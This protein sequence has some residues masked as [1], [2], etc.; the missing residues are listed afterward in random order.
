RVK[1]T[2]SVA[3]WGL[4]FALHIERTACAETDSQ[5]RQP[6]VFGRSVERTS[7]GPK[8]RQ[9]RFSTISKGHQDWTWDKIARSAKS[10]AKQQLLPR[11]MFLRTTGMRV[12]R[13]SH[14]LLRD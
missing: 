2:A 14:R 9:R 11:I 6:E 7:T 5:L 13:I 12:D 4:F 10:F 1:R 3:R 8:R